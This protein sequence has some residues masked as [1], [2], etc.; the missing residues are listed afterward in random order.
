MVI[1]SNVEF[2]KLAAGQSARLKAIA[3]ARCDQESAGFLTAADTQVYIKACMASGDKK[4]AQWLK[5]LIVIAKNGK[6][7]RIRKGAT[8]WED[9]VEEVHAL[10]AANEALDIGQHVRCKE[11]GRYGSVVDYNVDSKEYIIILDPFQVKTYKSNQIETV[12]SHKINAQRDDVLYL[13]EEFGQDIN[14]GNKVEISQGSGIDSGKIGVVVGP[15]KVKTNGRGIPTNIPGAY[16]PINWQSEVVIEFP[17]GSLSIMDK[18]R[19]RKIAYAIEDFDEDFEKEF[20]EDSAPSE[21]DI[22]MQDAGPLGG[23]TSVSAGGKF[24]GEFPTEDE[25]TMAIQAW[26]EENQFY[27]NVWKI[28]DHGNIIGPLELSTTIETVASHKINAQS[29]S[30]PKWEVTYDHLEGTPVSV[31][32]RGF[33]DDES[34]EWTE[35]RMYDDDGELYYSGRM[36]QYVDGFEPLDDYGMPNA[37]ATELRYLENGTWVSL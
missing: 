26:M 27:P 25:A 3:K 14:T 18:N 2:E 19:V 7:D 16:A 10:S 34:D 11:T 22:F 35:F 1:L 29:N 20:E 12:A 8:T 28:S 6:L 37:G 13:P 17:D 30:I 5:S 33:S 24:L 9:H 15:G 21:D 36:N 31:Q 4:A 32:S 23:R